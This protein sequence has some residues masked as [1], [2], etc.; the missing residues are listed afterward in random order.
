MCVN[1]PSKE[2]SF[3]SHSSRVFLQAQAG[4][5]GKVDTHCSPGASS[6]L[7]SSEHMGAARAVTPGTEVLILIWVNQASAWDP[8]RAWWHGTV[9][10]SLGDIIWVTLTPINH[11]VAVVDTHHLTGCLTLP[12][13]HGTLFWTSRKKKGLSFGSPSYI[14]ENM[15]LRVAEHFPRCPA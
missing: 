11:V 12:A 1:N 9:L 13:S 8:L 14:I 10:F 5:T 4:E 2:N 6:P 7:V 3:R 15:F